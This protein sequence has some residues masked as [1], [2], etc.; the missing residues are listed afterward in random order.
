VKLLPDLYDIKKTEKVNVRVRLENLGRRYVLL[1]R[2]LK[3]P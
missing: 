2:F 1:I 3:E